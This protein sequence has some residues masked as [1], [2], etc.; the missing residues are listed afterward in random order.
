[1]NNVK[2]WLLWAAWYV[3]LMHAFYLGYYL[4]TRFL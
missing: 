2:D 3:I 4:V 1:M